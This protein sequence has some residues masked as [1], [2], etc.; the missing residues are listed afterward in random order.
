MT[1]I[2]L[3]APFEKI[4]NYNSN[5]EIALRRAIILQ[6]IIDA[7]NT[8]TNIYA[9]RFELEAKKWLFGR[10]KSFTKICEEAE[11]SEDFV[12]SIAKET[13]KT[14]NMSVT[15]KILKNNTDV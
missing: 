7:T 4:K 5:P 3:Q 8:S 14:H 10:S 15:D 13:I 2:K 1:V 9:K 12:I 6:A 11:L